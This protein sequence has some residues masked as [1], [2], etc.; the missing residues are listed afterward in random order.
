MSYRLCNVNDLFTRQVV[1]MSSN[2]NHTGFSAPAILS[3]I[4]FLICWG[5][6][7]GVCFFPPNEIKR[8]FSR[9]EVNTIYALNF[10]HIVDLPKNFKKYAKSPPGCPA[11]AGARCTSWCCRTSSGSPCAGGG[12]R[13]GTRTG[14]RGRRCRRRRT[15]HG[16]RPLGKEASLVYLKP[17]IITRF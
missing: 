12:G 8:F 15:R 1:A 11:A 14:C 3:C 5:K 2:F 9:S 17:R 16:G 4:V 10:P 7:A 13:R 6:H